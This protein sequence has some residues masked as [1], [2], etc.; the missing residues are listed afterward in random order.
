MSI[1]IRDQIYK[2]LI[3][4]VDD[5]LI[6]TSQSYDEAIIRTVQHFTDFKLGADALSLVRSKGIAYGVNNDWSATR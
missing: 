3:F 5:T 6:D 2:A 4:D 1:Q